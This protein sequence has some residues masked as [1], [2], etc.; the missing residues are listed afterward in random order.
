MIGILFI[1]SSLEPEQDGV[2]DYTR[3]L[4]QALISKGNKVKIIALND[5]RLN[6]SSWLGVQKDND[7]EIE[8]LRLPESLTWNLRLHLANKFINEFDP[9]WIS[10]QFVPFGYQIKGLPF[11]LDKKLMQLSKKARWHVMF[12]ELS[13]NK[14]ESFKFRL[15]A[16]LQI[17]IIKSLLKGLK[18]D[19]V[20]TNTRVYQYTLEQL[21]YPSVILPLFSNIQRK[22]FD[23]ADMFQNRIPNYLV[24]ERSSYIVGT[25]FGTFSFK[26]WNLRSLLNKLSEQYANK[27]IVIAAIGK[28]AAGIVYWQNLKNEYPSIIFLE[29]GMQDAGFISY[30]LTHYTDFGILTTLPELSGKSGSFMAFKEHGIPVL[31]KE[32]DGQ[33]SAYDI[34]LDDSL[35]VIAEEDESLPIPKKSAPVSLLDQTAEAFLQLLN[36]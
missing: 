5:R 7:I 15:W 20:T 4:A 34:I 29:W 23:N 33:L 26:S 35:T 22:S 14:N 24:I 28:M 13:V 8:V 6:D 21:G 27:K 11:N 19:L 12:H 36:Q 25:L 32:P 17:R 30:W 9:D 1:C 16:L 10:L 18:P 3:K 2:G 31:C